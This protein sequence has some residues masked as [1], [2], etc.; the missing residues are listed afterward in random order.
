MYINFYYY[1]H[2]LFL[3]KLNL[4]DYHKVELFCFLRRLETLKKKA[5]LFSI[6]IKLD[7]CKLNNR[8]ALSVV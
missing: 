3:N 5:K 8:Q 2:K 4:K 6:V 1:L 7:E